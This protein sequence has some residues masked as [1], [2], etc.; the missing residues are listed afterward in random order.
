[1]SSQDVA[2]DLD[3]ARCAI[4][5]LADDVSNGHV[6]VCAHA[7]RR[8]RA[9]VRSARDCARAQRM[10]ADAAVADAESALRCVEAVVTKRESRLRTCRATVRRDTVRR[11]RGGTCGACGARGRRVP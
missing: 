10:Y 8:G 9:F 1:M 6:Q 4:A 2:L 3:D 7:K 11:E 5:R